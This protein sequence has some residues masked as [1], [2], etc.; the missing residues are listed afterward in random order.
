MY[1]LTSRRKIKNLNNM[2]IAD[3]LLAEETYTLADLLDPRTKYYMLNLTDKEREEFIKQKKIE[4]HYKNLIPCVVLGKEKLN[5]INTYQYAERKGL[6]QNMSYEQKQMLEK[7]SRDVSFWRILATTKKYL[8]LI[9][10]IMAISNFIID[11][12]F[13]ELY[14]II[15]P[16]ENYIFWSLFCIIIILHRADKNKCN[17]IIGQMYK[18]AQSQEK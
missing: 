3:E 16:E 2:K 10:G 13:P 11:M 9:T 14:N 1:I 8:A 15:Q 5:G 17:K 12:K 6:T 7:I 18:L 4:V